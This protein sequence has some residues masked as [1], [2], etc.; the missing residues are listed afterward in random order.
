MNRIEIECLRV[1]L[2]S[3]NCYLVRQT[4]SGF[5][6]I[7]DP[8]DDADFILVMS[9]FAGFGGQAFI[10]ETF[11]RVRRLKAEIRRRG[12]DC[13]I[14]VDG[15]VGLSNAKELHKAGVDIAVAGSSVFKSEDPSA[16][17][18]AMRR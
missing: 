7:I 3:T 10:P 11:D 1:G 14:E 6:A 9:V 8:G 15:G 4:D 5:L 12:L 2:I 17:I 16:T 13:K 18:A